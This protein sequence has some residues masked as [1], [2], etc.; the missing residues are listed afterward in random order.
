[1]LADAMGANGLA[2]VPPSGDLAA[3][4]SVEVLLLHP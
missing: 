2:I 1:M 3:G 4:T